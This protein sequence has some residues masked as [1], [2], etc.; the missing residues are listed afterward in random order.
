MVSQEKLKRM[1]LE[2]LIDAAYEA[3][4]NHGLGDRMAFSEPYL[5]EARRRMKNEG[6]QEGSKAKYERLDD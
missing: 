1:T 2:E 5:V 6:P 3:G 4:M